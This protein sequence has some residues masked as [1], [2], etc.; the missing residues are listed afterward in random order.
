MPPK[1]R[2]RTTEEKQEDTKEQENTETRKQKY[3]NTPGIL[4]KKIFTRIALS[5][6]IMLLVYFSSQNS[7][8]S[9]ALQSETVK[10]K[11]L[12]VP[13][14]KKYKKE[15]L[16]YKGCAPQ[17]CGR[18]VTDD[19][20]LPQESAQLLQIAK[21]GLSLS[22]SSGG[23]SILDLH[24]GAVSQG[25]SFVNVYQL[26][27]E[28]NLNVFTHQDFQVYRNVKNKIKEIIAFKFGIIPQY[29]YLT[30]PTFF[31][32]MTNRPPKTV[33]DEYWHIHV[34]K[35]T[36]PSFHYTSLIYLNDYNKDF[37][38]GRF[39]FVGKDL[40]MTVEPKA[41]R[42]SAFTSGAE[43]PHRVEKVTSGTRYALTV[44]FTCDKSSSIADPTLKK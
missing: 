31:S 25:S 4:W 39:V 1:Q 19:L 14:S 15:I 29:L 20:I 6:G 42:V 10:E 11:L 12:E 24:S 36:Y 9:F 18:L 23:A 16:K 8:K 26:M 28:N 37:T 21:K 13:C 33:H 38:G 32:Q 30:H 3:G 5:V 40:N 43:N 22:K 27:K 2:K 17:L 35:E 34:D 44:S 7:E 41:G